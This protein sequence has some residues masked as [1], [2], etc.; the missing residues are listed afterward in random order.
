MI[1]SRCGR[2]P[3]NKESGFCDEDEAAHKAA[4]EWQKMSIRAK[5]EANA[6]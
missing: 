6:K 3:A 5:A 1:C 2:A 4:V